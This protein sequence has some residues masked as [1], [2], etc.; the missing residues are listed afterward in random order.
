MSLPIYEEKTK[1]RARKGS[2][3][4]SDD[5]EEFIPAEDRNGPSK[6]QQKKAAKAAR[7][8]VGIVYKRLVSMLRLEEM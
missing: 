7:R 1:H 6:H 2:Q 4:A 3:S 5:R 8:N